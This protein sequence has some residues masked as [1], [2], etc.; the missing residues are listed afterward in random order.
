M[1]NMH[2]FLMPAVTGQISAYCTRH[3]TVA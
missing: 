1:D 2:P 3:F